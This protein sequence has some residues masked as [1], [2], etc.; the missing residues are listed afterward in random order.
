MRRDFCCPLF[1]ISAIQ[2]ERVVWI[3]KPPCENHL[4]LKKFRLLFLKPCE[5]FR[6]RRDVG[7]SD[8][9]TVTLQRN[10]FVVRRSD[11]HTVVGSCSQLPRLSVERCFD[12]IPNRQAI[13]ELSFT[14]PRPFDAVDHVRRCKFQLYPA[15]AVLVGNPAEAV[16]VLAIVDML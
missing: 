5:F 13:F 4:R 1:R 15:P 7:V 3:S 8:G 10:S 6:N 16:S 14:I 9:S 2:H 12:A 11:S